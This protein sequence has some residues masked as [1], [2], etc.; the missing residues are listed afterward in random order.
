MRVAAV[1]AR[2]ALGAI[3]D[4]RGLTTAAGGLLAMDGRGRRLIDD[5]LVL[6]VLLGLAGDCGV[7]CAARLDGVVPLMVTPDRLLPIE[8]MLDMEVVRM[9]TVGLRALFTRYWFIFPGLRGGEGPSVGNCRA[10]AIIENRRVCEKTLEACML[11]SSLWPSE[12]SGEAEQ[13]LVLG[14][15][16]G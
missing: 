16:N 3:T 5:T 8:E 12:D 2:D 11:A 15:G 13:R 9:C 1:G 6:L 14:S 4:M 7:P 10:F